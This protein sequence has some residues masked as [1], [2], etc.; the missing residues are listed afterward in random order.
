MSLIHAKRVQYGN[1]SSSERDTELLR[2]GYRMGPKW[3]WKWPP[4]VPNSL[5]NGIK[6]DRQ[7]KYQDMMTAMSQWQISLLKD[8]TWRLNQRIARSATLPSHWPRHLLDGE[9]N[10]QQRS[11]N[12]ILNWMPTQ[13][14]RD[15]L[16]D[17]RE[18]NEYSTESSYWDG[19]S[20]VNQVGT[21]AIIRMTFRGKPATKTLSNTELRDAE[22]F[23]CN[24]HSGFPR[25]EVHFYNGEYDHLLW[26]LHVRHG[27]IPYRPC[28]M[29]LA[30]SI[31]LKWSPASQIK[32]PT[33]MT[34]PRG[35]AHIIAQSQDKARLQLTSRMNAL[36]PLIRQKVNR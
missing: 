26:S 31:N 9:P 35:K 23:I 20:G 1:Q 34:M 18:L 19:H 15:Q 21:A 30:H 25:A 2:H 3:D 10:N 5:L 4:I 7:D 27:S 22:I 28:L 16:G 33:A 12:G 14:S 29:Q 6:R 11:P 36:G 17:Y 13:N 24:V 8:F 32:E